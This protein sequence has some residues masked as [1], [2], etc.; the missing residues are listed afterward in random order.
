MGVAL[1]GGMSFGGREGGE[2]VDICAKLLIKRNSVDLVQKDKI[3][4]LRLI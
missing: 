1:F 4:Y 2:I 3:E